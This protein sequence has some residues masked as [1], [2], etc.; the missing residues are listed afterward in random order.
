MVN[1]FMRKIY[2]RLEVDNYEFAT[3]ISNTAILMSPLIPWN[4]AN[5]VIANTLE[6]SPIKIVPYAF[7]LYIPIVYNYIRL[8]KLKGTLNRISA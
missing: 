7:Y 2:E 8:E 1:R 5:F 3:D 6:V 4:I